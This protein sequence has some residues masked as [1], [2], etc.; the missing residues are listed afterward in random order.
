[1]LPSDYSCPSCKCKACYALHRKGFDWMMSLF[2]LRPARCLTCTRRFYARYTL[3]ED[4][5]YLNPL[6]RP[7]EVDKPGGSSPDKAYKKAA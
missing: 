6:G 1:M 3:S 5:K 4:G 7:A 2:G